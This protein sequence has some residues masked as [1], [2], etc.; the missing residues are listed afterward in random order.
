MKRIEREYRILVLAASE[1]TE[2]Q[3]TSLDTVDEINAQWL[4]ASVTHLRIRAEVRN[5]KSAIKEQEGVAEQLLQEF[6]IVVA[7]LAVNSIADT[8]AA[9]G[10]LRR[11]IDP[12]VA[13]Y[14]PVL[15]YLYNDQLGLCGVLRPRIRHLR[16]F[17]DDNVH[18]TCVRTSEDLNIALLE[19]LATEVHRLEAMRL[20]S[21]P[22]TEVGPNGFRVGYAPKGDK[23]E[24]IPDTP[25][26]ER[27]MVLRR[28]DDVIEAEHE[29]CWTKIW[30]N[31]HQHRLQRNT[32]GQESLTEDQKVAVDQAREAAKRMEAKYGRENLACD[33]MELGICCGKLSALA[34]VLGSEWDESLDT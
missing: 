26:E 21:L 8:G 13:A 11:G 2:A 5:V 1:A 32:A 20:A 30:W 16:N 17:D 31:R 24:R 34:W 6:D 23:V 4:G 12:F 9:V 22:G 27:L 18:I 29:K 19:E 3:Q 28:A 7:L 15:I 25:G 33:D 10:D 14:K